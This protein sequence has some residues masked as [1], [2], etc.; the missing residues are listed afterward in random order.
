MTLS[1][2][3]LRKRA[4]E[5]WNYRLRTWGSGRWAHRCRPTSIVFSLTALCTARCVHCDIWKNKD[6]E[7]PPTVDQYKTVLR[8]L[9]DWLGSV[10]VT[11][12]GGEALLKPY[13]PELVAYG[14]SAGLFMEVLTHGYWEDQGKIERLALANPWRVTVSFDGFGETHN[15]IRGRG[16]FFEYTSRSIETLLRVRRERKL[17][18]TIQLK[19]VIM[20]HN[21]HDTTAVA[22]FASHEGMDV[23]YQPIEQNYNTPEDPRWFEHTDNWPKDTE[24]VVQVIQA[25]VRM[26]RDGYHIANSYAQLEAMI[27]Y[28]RTPDALRVATQAHSAHERTPTCNA[29]TN[30]ELRANGDVI[31]CWGKPPVG[32]IKERPVRNIWE[33]RPR[34][35]SHGECCLFRRCSEAE[36]N[37]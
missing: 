17:H 28:F 18:Y 27:P 32:N 3:Y 21:L 23:F 9:R 16:G 13:T 4:Y 8:D 15:K 34:W 22:K 37:R 5:A 20:A 30:L 10:Q 6:K 26:K 24:R 11:F 12:S 1:M 25:L 2:R 33:N 31:A 29:L 35:W 7:N 19:N 36:Q 14:S